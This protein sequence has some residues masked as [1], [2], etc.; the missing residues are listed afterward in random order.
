MV[1]VLFK[2]KL[3][4]FE[5]IKLQDKIYSNSIGF[6]SDWVFNCLIQGGSCC[7]DPKN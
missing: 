1:V 7:R 6:I 3:S 2:F 4:N 5:L